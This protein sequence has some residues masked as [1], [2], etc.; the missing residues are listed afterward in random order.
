VQRFPWPKRFR[1]RALRNAFTARWHEREAEV[2]SDP[3]ALEA[4]REAKRTGNFDIAN[5]Y[6]GQSAGLVS[7]TVSAS[8]IVQGLGEGAERLLRRRFGELL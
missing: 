3:A 7:G 1:G 2:L 4:F 5:I 6:A 8:T